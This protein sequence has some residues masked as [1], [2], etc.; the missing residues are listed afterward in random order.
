[1]P[2]EYTESQKGIHSNV[3]IGTLL[4]G[5]QRM[6]AQI[7]PFIC[8][9]IAMIYDSLENLYKC[10]TKYQKSIPPV[11]FQ[12]YDVDNDGSIARDELLVLLHMM[13]GSNITEEQLG[14][15]ADRTLLEADLDEDGQIS[16]EEF[17]KVGIIYRSTAGNRYMEAV[18]IFLHL[19]IEWQSVT[20]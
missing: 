8:R 14:A 19:F 10:I 16:F 6:K 7:D 1:M 17:I 13:V 11:A 2:L 4:S 5:S 9:V 12:M 20:S 15:I 3:I 18:S